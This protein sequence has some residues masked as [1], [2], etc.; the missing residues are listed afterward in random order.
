MP[1]MPVR[2]VIGTDYEAARADFVKTKNPYGDDEVMLVPAI[3]PDVSLLHAFRADRFGNCILSSATD[4]ALLARASRAV[5]VSAE[6]I[7]E[8]EKLV[9]SPRETFLSRVHVTAVV[10]AKQGAYPTACGSLYPADFGLLRSYLEKVKKPGGLDE[11][12]DD[13]NS[14]RGGDGND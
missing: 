2:G 5:I 10:H 3:T 12:L 8:T 9:A 14:R 4:D 13:L 7:V 11:F 6:E 1:F